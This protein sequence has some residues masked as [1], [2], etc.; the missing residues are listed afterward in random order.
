MGFAFPGG[1]STRVGGRGGERG[2]LDGTCSQVW[3]FLPFILDSRRRIKRVILVEEWTGR[4]D[5]GPIF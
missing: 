5:I 3:F 2:D 4:E 1:Q